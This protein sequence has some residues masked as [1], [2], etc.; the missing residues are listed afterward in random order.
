MKLHCYDQLRPV[1]YAFNRRNTKLFHRLFKVLSIT[2]VLKYKAVVFV[3]VKVALKGSQ[4]CVLCHMVPSRNS[5]MK[6][7]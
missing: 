4:V 2:H 1:I 5:Y 3:P 7:F 6:N